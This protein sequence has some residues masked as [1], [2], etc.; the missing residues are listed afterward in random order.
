MGDAAP[1]DQAMEEI[2][3]SIRR[4]INGQ[5]EADIKESIINPRP[6]EVSTNSETIIHGKTISGSETSSRVQP[7]F[8]HGMT[9]DDDIGAVRSA[10]ANIAENIADDGGIPAG[11]IASK[12]DSN[13]DID[14]AAKKDIRTPDT[15]DDTASVRAYGAEKKEN[16]YKSIEEETKQKY[17]Q[18]PSGYIATETAEKSGLKDGFESGDSK[19]S[20]SKRSGPDLLQAENRTEAF[21]RKAS[22]EIE[23]GIG[24]LVDDL[25]GTVVEEFNSY[26]AAR[27]TPA[28][29]NDT[30]S[31]FREALVAPETDE[32]VSASMRRLKRAIEDSDAAKIETMLRPMLSQWLD[33]NLPDIVERIVQKEIDRI[34]KND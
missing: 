32:I 13:S 3:A 2:L 33:K 11:L 20:Q 30:E 31:Q 16:Y 4:K 23:P 1:K 24:G 8:N 28:S 27:E 9:I 14:P 26:L 29:K 6:P 34:T 15:G 17:E 19:S 10:L 12:R 22:G 18:N 25:G 21:P 5:G 7:D